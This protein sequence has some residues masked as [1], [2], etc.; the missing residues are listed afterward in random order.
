MCMKLKGLNCLFE[1]IVAITYLELACAGVGP[2]VRLV[3]AARILQPF[4]IINTH[5]DDVCGI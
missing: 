5:D 4:S 3:E 2:L 1:K